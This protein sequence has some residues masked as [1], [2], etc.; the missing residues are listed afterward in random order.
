MSISNSKKAL[1]AISSLAILGT[2][3]NLLAEAVSPAKVEATLEKGQSLVVE[4]KVL[5]PETT[6]KL[7]FVLIVDLSGSYGDDLINIKRL[8]PTLFDDIRA[9][10]PDSRFGL[11]TFVDFPFSPWG[12][13]SEYAYRLDQNLTA[14]KAAWL[15]AVNN[16]VTRYGA[17]EPESQNEALY[18]AATGAGR[19]MPISTDGDYAD[20]G[21]IPA[22]NNASF[23]EDATRIIAITTDAS[24]HQKNNYGYSFPYPGASDAEAIAALQSAGIKVIAIRAPGSGA[25]MDTL[26]AKTDGAVVTTSSSSAEIVTAVLAG[27]KKVTYT[28]S[29]VPNLACKPLEFAYVPNAY[30][31]IL[32]GSGVSFQET[33]TVPD[34][35]AK[36][37]LDADGQIKCT[38]D[39]L[40]DDTTIGVQTVAI[41]VPMNAPPEAK[42]QDIATFADNTCTAPGDINSDSL[43]PDG[44]AITL[45]YSPEGPYSVGTTPVT[46]TVTDTAGESDNC[47]A[48]VTVTDVTPPTLTVK[49]S[50]AVLLWPPDHNYSQSLSLSDCGLQIVDSCGGTLDPFK[51]SQIISIYS[52]EPEDAKGNGDGDTLKDAIILSNV[53]FKVRSERDGNGNGRVYGIVFKVFDNNGNSA[54]GICRIGVPKSQ[55]GNV[56]IDD[57]AK[58]NY[59]P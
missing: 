30:S 44:D 57:S 22:G 37:D 15:S 9:K 32:G 8:A 4:K 25:Q 53:D 12:A 18:Q 1:W 36:S 11:A 42:C 2:A 45:K 55:N 38:V 5:V 6:P 16:M 17:D 34:S 41:T 33:I 51:M 27:L 58:S 56:P 40:A 21:E 13:T 54:Q 31:D 47:T 29:A 23:R 59:T 35:I 20:P 10:I 43:D 52:D 48:T 7:D 3:N 19:E 28:I 39:F 46:L 50:I 26:A 14:D 49:D 24:F